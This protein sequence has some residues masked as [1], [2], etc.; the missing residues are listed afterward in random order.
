MI[1]RVPPAELWGV[2]TDQGRATA[3]TRAPAKI[4]PRP[5]GAFEFMGGAM[6]GYYVEVEHPTKLTMQ[7][8]LRNSLHRPRVRLLVF[9]RSAAVGQRHRR[10]QRRHAGARR[11]S[12]LQSACSSTGRCK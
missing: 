1:W 8:R 7:W 3:Y 11:R 4:D 2:L 5:T 6:S 10:R 9:R 12:H